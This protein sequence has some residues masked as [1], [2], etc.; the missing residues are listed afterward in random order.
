MKTFATSLLGGAIGPSISPQPE[1]EKHQ[2]DMSAGTSGL[3]D[4]HEGPT[5][6]KTSALAG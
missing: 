4:G 5:G 2:Q 1:R 3:G 6:V